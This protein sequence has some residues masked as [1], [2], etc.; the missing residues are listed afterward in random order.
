MHEDEVDVLD[1]SVAIPVAE[2]EEIVEKKEEKE[3][4]NASNRVKVDA[5]AILN[6]LSGENCQENRHGSRFLKSLHDE[7]KHANPVIVHCSD[8]QNKIA[9]KRKTQNAL[10][11]V[12]ALG[13]EQ[14]THGINSLPIQIQIAFRIKVLGLFTLQLLGMTLLTIIMTYSPICRPSLEEFANDGKGGAV[15]GSVVVSFVA[16]FLLFLVKYSFP[17]NY[18]M[19]AIFTCVQSIAVTTL[20]LYFDTHASVFACVFCFFV[21]LLTTIFSS[22]TRTVRGCTVLISTPIA[23]IISYLLV[24]IISCLI[25]A[26]QGSNFMSGTTFVITLCFS[27][28]VIVWFA[29]DASCMYQI[30]STDEYMQGVIFF[31]TDL[32]LL[33]IFLLVMG[34]CIAA[35]DG[36]APMGCFGN[37]APFVAESDIPENET[38]RPDTPSNSDVDPM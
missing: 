27:L 21:I 17:V 3:E 24:G 11:A 30:M 29:F 2:E 22:R 14:S 35:C 9:T 8:V 26:G 16:L 37:C 18:F 28:G 6:E 36:G 31:Y 19:L 33:L 23:A 38:P 20:G 10:L 4:R 25:Y 12:T 7:V 34:I 5:V 15:A 1:T 13:N 32:V